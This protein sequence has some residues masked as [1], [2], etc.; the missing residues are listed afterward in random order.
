[1]NYLHCLGNLKKEKPFVVIR[2]RWE[3]NTRVDLPETLCEYV[4]WIQLP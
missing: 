3:D 2:C 1:M 4:D